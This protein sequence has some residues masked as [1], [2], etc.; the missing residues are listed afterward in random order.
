MTNRSLIVLIAS[1][2]TLFG[3]TSRTPEMQLVADVAE[4]MGGSRGVLG[5]ET[6]VLQ[7]TSGRQ[8]R[9]GQ[10]RDPDDNLPYW[11]IDEYR[12]EIDLQTGRWRLTLTRT[13]AFSTGYPV[14]REE[15][16]LGMDGNVAY[17]VGPDGTARRVDGAV[18]R[19]RA[20]EFYHYP[21]AI[22]QLTESEGATVSNLRQED[23]QDVVDVTSADGEIY[24]LYVD[25]DTKHPSKIVS[26]ADHPNLGDVLLTTE[27]DDYQETGGLG[28]FEARLTVPRRIT[29]RVDEWPI[30]EL[31]VAIDMNQDLGDLSAPEDARSAAEPEFQANVQ[32]VRGG[33]RGLAFERPV[34]PQ[35]ACRV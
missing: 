35:R 32:V 8:Y 15:Q 10:N 13:S 20:A 18:A 29:A 22:V 28:G 30:W 17:D 33:Q 11:E 23:G 3:C 2:L 16:V 5:A 9:L 24:T 7:G 19:A 25:P 4:A 12:R 1:T 34:P 14:L 26:R 27:F 21:V 31:R 6:L